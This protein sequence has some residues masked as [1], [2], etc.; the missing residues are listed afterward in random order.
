MNKKVKTQEL[1][2]CKTAY[3]KNLFKKAEYPWEILPDIKNYIYDIIKGGAEGFTEIS[4]NVF[5]GENVSE[6][7][8]QLFVEQMEENYPDISVTI[9]DG[10]QKVYRFLLGIE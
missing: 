8:R 7:E 3:L 2:E 4:E 9:F 6:E 1:F 5:I 10:G